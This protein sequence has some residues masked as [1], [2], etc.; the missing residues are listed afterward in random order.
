ME[1]DPRYYLAAHGLDILPWMEDILD[2]KYSSPACSTGEGKVG[3]ETVA[4]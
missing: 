2:G 4:T 1:K 3:I